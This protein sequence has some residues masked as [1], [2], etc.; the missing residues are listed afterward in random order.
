MLKRLIP[1]GLIAALVA[2][3][4]AAASADELADVEKLLT[5]K[6]R[7]LKS[8]RMKLK[9]VMDMS[10]EGYETRGESV[11]TME[12]VRKDGKWYSRTETRD[13]STTKIADE[14]QSSESSGLMVCDGEHVYSFSE[15]DGQKHC[16]RT[17][18]EPDADWNRN[19]ITM[20]RENHDLKLL[21]EES[22]DGTA[23]YVIEARPKS[24][25]QQA[26]LGGRSVQY[27]RKSDGLM[28]KMVSYTPDDKP[29]LTMTCSDLE[30]NVDIDPSRFK[31]V[32]PAGV[33]V[34][35]LTQ[36]EKPAEP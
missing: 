8:M 26:G 16:T 33:Q 31:F 28:I 19:P 12:W 5:E 11:S 6:Y 23:C 13:K 10:M 14:V 18:A 35:D 4:T 29:L 21:P 30:V 3:G 1:F 34:I 27:F 7:E 15:T 9:T 22:I 2:G 20:M 17:R 24:G 25:S 36:P 32:P